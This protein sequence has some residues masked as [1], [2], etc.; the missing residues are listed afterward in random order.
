MTATFENPCLQG[1]YAPWTEENNYENLTEI[2]G[3][4]P[5][6]LNGAL[7]RNGPN[8]QFPDDNAHWFEGD[9]MIHG[10]FFE[11]GKVCY[12]NRWIRTPRFE[13]EHK[14]GKGLFG[15]L[16]DRSK[17]DPSTK[18]VSTNTANTNIVM[19]AGKL[20]A[21]QETSLP[22][23]MNPINLHTIGEWKCNDNIS[24]MSAHPHFDPQTNEMHTYAYYFDKPEV[25][26]FVFNELGILTK[27]KTIEVPFSS[28][29]HDFFI[30]KDYVIF[31]VMP[32]TT[33]LERRKHGKPP[34]MWEPE[35]GAHIC[36]MPKNGSQKDIIWYSLDAFY[37]YHFMNAYQEGDKV[38]LDGMKSQSATL[39]PDKN[40]NVT[41]D[42][43]HPPQLTRWEFSLT[44]K[45]SRVSQL[46]SVNAEFPRFDERFTGLPYQHGFCS[47]STN[48]ENEEGDFDSLIHYDLINRTSKTRSFGR[49]SNP[50]EPIFVPYNASI[51]E[52]DGVILTTAYN[53]ETDKSDLYILDAMNIDK[54]PLAIVHLPNRVPNGF[55]GNWCDS[56]KLKK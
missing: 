15:T 51:P 23:E 54:E 49:Y 25:D 55:H 27:S 37:V 43:E 13:L 33:S 11:N 53:A 41:T 47:A 5:K 35:L 42:K 45:S 39:F 8:P 14:A 3:E 48:P 30:T 24:H 28:F 17:A 1:N 36:I 44:N 12:Q 10:F 32:L 31:P 38:I 50:S 4:I 34:I 16:S 20:L 40:G 6:S 26:Y 52:G 19:H 56:E 22:I 18:D 29:M 9:G 2:T 46:D 21:L 7:Y